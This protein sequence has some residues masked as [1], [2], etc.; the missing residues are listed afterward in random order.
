MRL[1]FAG[2]ASTSAVGVALVCVCGDLRAGKLSRR[3]VLVALD[4]D[5][6]LR[7]FRDQQ[8]RL[9][10]YSFGRVGDVARDGRSDRSVIG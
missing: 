6:R 1:V 8:T 2:S 7:L 4:C 10:V 5:Q 3:D 9:P